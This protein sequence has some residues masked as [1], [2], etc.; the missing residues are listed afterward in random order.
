MESREEFS[1][2]PLAAR[3]PY[4]LVTHRRWE[5]MLAD[6][7]RQ[8]AQ[9]GILS[10]V[11]QLQLGLRVARSRQPYAADGQ[12][13]ALGKRPGFERANPVAPLLHEERRLS[14]PT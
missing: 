8:E 6:H 13:H 2:D 4:S 5:A 7:I 14:L 12:R 1:V 9:L 10:G 3:R 11:K